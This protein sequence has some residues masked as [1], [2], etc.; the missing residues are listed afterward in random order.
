MAELPRLSIVVTAYTL[1][2]LKDIHEL[3]DSIGGQSYRE[4]EV[5][6]VIERS[7]ELLDRIREHL[8]MRKMLS[9]WGT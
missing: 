6:F 1:E 8:R 2:R 9:S 7:P 4:M 3:L 5:V